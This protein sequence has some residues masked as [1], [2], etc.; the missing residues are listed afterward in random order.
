M[1]TAT[2]APKGKTDQVRKL[3]AQAES[4]GV[5]AEEAEAFTAKAAVLMARYGI[6]EMM[7]RAAIDDAP[8]PQTPGYKITPVAPPFHHQK[9]DMLSRLGNAMRLHPVIHRGGGETGKYRESFEVELLGSP[10]DIDRCLVLYES[11]LR[12]ATRLLRDEMPPGAKS[13]YKQ[14]WLD[15]F[16]LRVAARVKDAEKN[17]VLEYDQRHELTGPASAALVL[18]SWEEQVL[19]FRAKRHP[20]LV[21]AKGRSTSGRG[22]DAG[23]QA[24]ARATLNQA[25]LPAKTAR[26]LPR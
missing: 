8:K 21:T 11:M 23:W 16:S 17:A 20:H 13:A 26:A 5:T 1:S 7:I 4:F 25:G 2:I 15:G 18:Q 22:F 6:D 3:L 24:G 19:V 9:K 14:S 10:T 12:Q